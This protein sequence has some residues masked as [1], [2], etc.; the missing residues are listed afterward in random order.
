MIVMLAIKFPGDHVRFLFVVLVSRFRNHSSVELLRNIN[1]VKGEVCILIKLS[2][3][4]G[5]PAII[6][7]RH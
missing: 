6:L 2:N 5:T 7:V 4:L 3:Q 1:I